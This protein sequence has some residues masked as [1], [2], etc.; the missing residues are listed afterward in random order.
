M[1]QDVALPQTMSDALSRVLNSQVFEPRV[2]EQGNLVFIAEL[3]IFIV[4]Q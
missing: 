3:F 2:V 4:L 1:P